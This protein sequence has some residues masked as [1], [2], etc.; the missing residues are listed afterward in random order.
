MAQARSQSPIN[1]ERAR[2]A[3][4]GAFV[5]NGLALATVISRTPAIRDGLGLSPAHL[6]LLLLCLSFGAVA[7]LPLSGPVVHRLG[8]ARSVLTGAFSV[9][10]GLT[11]LGAALFT[12]VV[13]LAA[14]GLV[15]CGLGIGL[16]DVAMN[17]EGADVERKLGRSLMPRLHAAFSVGNVVGAGLSMASA[18]TAT[19]LAVQ[20]LV[21]AALL[22]LITVG[23]VRRFLPAPVEATTKHR[24][25][26]GTLRAWREP[27]TLALGVLV[28]A[29]AFTEGSGTDWMAVALVD[30]HGANETIGAAGYGLFVGAM[31]VCRMAS[32][33]LLDRFGR[34]VMLRATAVLGLIGLALVVF[35]GT[36]PVALVGAAVWG[37]GTA[38]GFPVGM[39]AAADDPERAAARVSVASSIGYTAF[40]AGPPVIGLLAEHAGILRALLVVTGALVL[41]LLASGASRP[42]AGT[43]SDVVVEAG[44]PSRQAG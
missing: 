9:A 21:I 19:P 16:W 17:V 41:G 3:V 15:L 25:G 40:L 27:R 38:L 11:T 13:A 24:T 37:A 6:G 36:T 1:V 18:A 35:G 31:T 23:C 33:R 22:P 30:G 8:P 28:L 7:V 14:V 44:E 12:G 39:S 34:V 4:A 32:V 10:A 43:G 2:V 42:L 29:F 26:S 20:V 5:T